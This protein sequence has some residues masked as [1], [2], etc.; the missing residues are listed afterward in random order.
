MCVAASAR[1]ARRATPES[2]PLKTWGKCDTLP[3]R[4]E[5]SIRA[6]L[7]VGHDGSGVLNSSLLLLAGC[8]LWMGHNRNWF[9]STHPRGHSEE[10]RRWK[11][12]VMKCFFCLAHLKAACVSWC[13]VVNLQMSR[14][15][16][17]ELKC[18]RATRARAGRH[19]KRFVSWRSRW[20]VFLSAERRS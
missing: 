15:L 16:I 9:L 5:L 8:S 10:P 18:L 4:N 13:S 11:A 20:G 14:R 1:V 6:S 2:G 3:A 7:A 12:G 17:R 19:I